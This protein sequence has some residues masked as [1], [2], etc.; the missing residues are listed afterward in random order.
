MI[1]LLNFPT[2]HFV[3]RTISELLYQSRRKLEMLKL[4][5]MLFMT[6]V[7]PAPFPR[8]PTHN[9]SGKRCSSQSGASTNGSRSKEMTAKSHPA[10]SARSPGGKQLPGE[11]LRLFK[12]CET[13][14]TS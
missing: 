9:Q 6:L 3:F 13:N 2:A 10:P 14:F 11:A 12:N 8:D 5:G 1:C 4:V 7:L